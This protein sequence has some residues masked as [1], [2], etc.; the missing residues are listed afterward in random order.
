MPREPVWRG[1]NPAFGVVVLLLSLTSGLQAQWHHSLYTGGGYAH[2]LPGTPGDYHYPWEVTLLP[3]VAG[4]LEVAQRAA[5]PR[6]AEGSHYQLGYQLDFNRFWGVFTELSYLQSVPWD[7][8]NPL[9]PSGWYPAYRL[10]TYARSYRSHLGIRF[11]IGRPESSYRRHWFANWSFSLAGGASLNRTR[12]YHHLYYRGES[13][14][15]Q[16]TPKW[17]TRLGLGTAYF[18]Q[19]DI[20][21]QLW[22]AGYLRFS[23]RLERGHYR[24]RWAQ[25]LEM[26]LPDHLKEDEIENQNIYYQPQELVY[27]MHHWMI[28]LAL[29]WQFSR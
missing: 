14:L 3:P 2:S 7:R 10:R 18:A 22:E 16:L 20:N 11:T 12:I 1:F 26:K 8:S 15:I 21:Y 27:P 5:R 29:V 25:H 28:N 6:H 24:T 17:R 19:I 23:G 4:G 13:Q 9:L